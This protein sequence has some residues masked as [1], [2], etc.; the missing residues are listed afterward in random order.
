MKIIGAP[1]LR[2]C[3][4]GFNTL[5]PLGPEIYFVDVVCP[6]YLLLCFI[7][8]IGMYACCKGGVD[9]GREMSDQVFG[10][11]MYGTV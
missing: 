7:V 11:A 4:F 8:I 9:L 3:C 2:P 5:L 10:E 6:P 1:V